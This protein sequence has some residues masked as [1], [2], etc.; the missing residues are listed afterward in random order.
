MSHLKMCKE[1][2]MTRQPLKKLPGTC[3]PYRVRNDG[4]FMA[5]AGTSGY[6]EDLEKRGNN[7]DIIGYCRQNLRPRPWLPSLEM[8]LKSPKVLSEILYEK[9]QQSRFL[10]TCIWSITILAALM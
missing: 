8:I 4:H 6:I 3:Q 2:C 9:F 10:N 7:P 1:S 5:G